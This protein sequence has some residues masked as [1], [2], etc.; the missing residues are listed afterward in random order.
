MLDF[1]NALTLNEA[2]KLAPGTLDGHASAVSLWRWINQGLDTGNGERLRMHGVRAGNQ[3]FTTRES[4]A[5]F[6]EKMRMCRQRKV[7]C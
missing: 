1:S 2:C 6:V 4:V 5:E 3:W 7:A